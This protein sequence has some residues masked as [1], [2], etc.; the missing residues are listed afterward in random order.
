MMGGQS[1]ATGVPQWV[2]VKVK[3]RGRLLVVHS[4][5]KYLWGG[6]ALSAA[7]TGHSA[8]TVFAISSTC[9]TVLPYSVHR[10]H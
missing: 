4:H 6:A 5:I 3:N 2:Q 7:H 9:R 10:K 8:M 1:F